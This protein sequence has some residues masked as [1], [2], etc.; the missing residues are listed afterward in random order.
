[1]LGF[2]DSRDGN[3]FEAVHVNYG[4]TRTTRMVFTK[5]TPELVSGKTRRK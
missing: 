3:E 1:M 2:T 5:V 4:S